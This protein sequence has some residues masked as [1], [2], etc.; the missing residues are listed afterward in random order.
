MTASFQ[1]N[2]S[3][4]FVEHPLSTH[5]IITNLDCFEE[6]CLKTNN[7]QILKK[8]EEDNLTRQVDW[9]GRQLRNS[10]SNS[11]HFYFR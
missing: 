1:S 6:I 8:E 11:I 9:A 7:E 2:T 3:R 4:A 5:S 10:N